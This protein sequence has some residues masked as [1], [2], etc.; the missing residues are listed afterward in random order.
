MSTEKES[1]DNLENWLT[2]QFEQALNTFKEIE[3]FYVGKQKENSKKYS[4]EIKSSVL[5]KLKKDRQD[6]WRFKE[7]I[8]HLPKNFVDCKNDEEEALWHLSKILSETYDKLNKPRFEDYIRAYFKYTQKELQ[9]CPACGQL[10]ETKP[11]TNGLLNVGLDHILPKSKYPQ[12]ALSIENLIPICYECNNA[13]DD[14][15]GN[16]NNLPSFRKK[17]KEEN[18][19]SIQIEYTEEN[20]KEKLPKQLTYYNLYQHLRINPLFWGNYSHYCAQKKK[21]ADQPPIFQ[22]IPTKDAFYAWL[23]VYDLPKRMERVAHNCMESLLQ[24][25][26]QADLRGPE[27][28]W[29]HLEYLALAN[30]EEFKTGSPTHPYIQ[31]WQDLL[32]WVLSDTDH[33][34]VL[35][36][37]LSD[38]SLLYRR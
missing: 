8:N 3:N 35:W 14:S 26:R 28:V 1:P 24:Q 36:E 12:F 7:T 27:G 30:Q 16:F 22:D 18:L 13:K 15:M 11:K 20:K 5:E 17:I 29:Q 4:P 25:L 34:S 31:V 2:E 6:F 32:D 38:R 37:E 19:K 10:L 23:K 9:R 33:V 21:D